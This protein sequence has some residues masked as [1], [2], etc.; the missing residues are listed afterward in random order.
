MGAGQCYFTPVILALRRLTNRILSSRSTQVMHQ[1]PVSKQNNFLNGNNGHI[2]LFLSKRNTYGFTQQ[3]FPQVNC[4]CPLIDYENYHLFLFFYFSH[5]N[6][7]V[8]FTQHRNCIHSYDGMIPYNRQCA[9]WHYRFSNMKA[10]PNSN[11]SD[12][13]IS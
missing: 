5:D 3:C 8:N 13:S 4:R 9:K 12:F 11:C 1:D 10:S 7:M 6:L 2:I